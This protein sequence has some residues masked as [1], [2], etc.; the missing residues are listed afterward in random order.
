MQLSNSSMEKYNSCP[1]AYDLHY[2]KKIRS[3]LLSSALYF[4]GYIGESI[5][6]HI[7]NREVNPIQMFE[8]LMQE[9]DINGVKQSLP[10]N[11]NI[12]YFLGDFDPEVLTDDDWREIEIFRKELGLEIDDHPLKFEDFRQEYKAE[13]ISDLDILAYMNLHF[14]YSMLRK[15]IMILQGFISDLVPRI[16]KVH[17][18]EIPIKIDISSPDD[19]PLSD[20]IIGYIDLKCDFELNE[21]E[22]EMLDRK[23][24]DIV[25][26]VFDFKTSSGR[27]YAKKFQESAQLHLYEFCEQTG[28]IGYFVAVKKIKRPKRGDRKGDEFAEIQTILMNSDTE[29]Q[30]HFLDKAEETLYNIQMGN[31][32]KNLSACSN[33]FGRPCNFINY[34]KHGDKTNLIKKG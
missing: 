12:R 11:A 4:G 13:V 34:C 28:V 9:V 6:E 15:G 20:Y 31:F 1:K 21:K 24:G 18:I 16:H 25:T 17:G 7:V 2:N 33:Q 5:Q 23:E 30:D 14:W 8:T 26:G 22:A 27:Y 10:K 29:L 32:E 3:T 19:K